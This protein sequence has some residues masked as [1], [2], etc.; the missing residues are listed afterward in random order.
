MK[1]AEYSHIL[2]KHDLTVQEIAVMFGA[3]SEHCFRG[4]TA[5]KKRMK[6]I[7]DLIQHVEDN[8]IKK[9]KS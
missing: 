3:K 4:S 6:G 9:I 1:D 8:I 2:R 7:C 5:F